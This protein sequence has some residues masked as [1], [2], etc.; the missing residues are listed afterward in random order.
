[1][2]QTEKTFLSEAQRAHEMAVLATNPNSKDV[3]LDV[4]RQYRN[5]A[6][7]AGRRRD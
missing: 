4:A 7:L 5:L 3:W 2:P 6:R 1:M